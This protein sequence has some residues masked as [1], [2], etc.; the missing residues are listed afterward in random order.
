M[1]A[2]GSHPSYFPDA[3][4]FDFVMQLGCHRLLT[5]KI[6]TSRATLFLLFLRKPA[7]RVLMVNGNKYHEH[8]L[9]FFHIICYKINPFIIGMEHLLSVEGSSVVGGYQSL[10]H[11]LYPTHY[12]ATMQEN[13]N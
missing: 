11:W 4:G 12:A 7:G 2:Y 10:G 3:S 8:W 13:T 5:D 9:S 1:L 6:I